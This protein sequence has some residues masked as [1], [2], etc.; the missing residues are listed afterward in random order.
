VTIIPNI[1]LDI[2]TASSSSSSARPAAA[3]P[4]CCA[5]RRAGGHHGGTISIDGRDVTAKRRPSASSRWCS[6]PTL[7]P[8]MTVAKNIAFPL[9]MAG[10]SQETIDKKVKD[11]ARV[12][13]LTNYLERGPGSSPA[14]SASA[15]PSAAPSCASPR[16]PVRRAAVEP[17][18]RAARA[19][20]P[21][22]L[23]CTKPRRR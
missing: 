5:D 16:L 14:A 8:H 22:D 15:S 3:S 20:A 18:R 13:N 23:A 1:D 21:R 12:L 10:E 6:S 11:A 2:A 4:P 17:R 19:D 9:K 7:Y